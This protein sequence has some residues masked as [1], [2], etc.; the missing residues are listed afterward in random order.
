MDNQA[1]IRDKVKNLKRNR[2]VAAQS[3]LPKKPVEKRA[4]VTTFLGCC[5]LLMTFATLAGMFMKNGNVF[6]SSNNHRVVKAPVHNDPV[7]NHPPVVQSESHMSQSD[8]NALSGRVESMESKLTLWTHRQWM[9][10]LAL[11]ENANISRRIDRQYHGNVDSG[12]ITFDSRWQMSK[13]PETM[14]VTPDEKELIRN[15][16]K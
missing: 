16:P 10:G 2:V 8:G 6:A 1:Y 4:F 11:N 5:I 13:I 9:M 15:G 7:V 3:V 12:F 14:K